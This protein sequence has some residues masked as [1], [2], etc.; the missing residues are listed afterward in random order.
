MDIKTL[1]ENQALDLFTEMKSLFGWKGSIFTQADLTDIVSQ[2]NDENETQLTNTDITNSQH[3][4]RHFED[5]LNNDGIAS[6]Q[7][8]LWEAKLE[9]EKTQ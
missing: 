5:E 9:K 6:L 4:Q 1:T 7:E 3:W 2:W 8:A